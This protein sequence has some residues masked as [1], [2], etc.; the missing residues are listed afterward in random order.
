MT[1][2]DSDPGRRVAKDL[3]IPFRK[4]A[5]GAA[6]FAATYSVGNGILRVHVAHAAD[7]RV[8][9]PAMVHV[10]VEPIEAV[11]QM[12][13]EPAMIPAGEQ[14]IYLYMIRD[15]AIPSV[16]CTVKVDE[17]TIDRRTLQ[18]R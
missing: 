4:V 18:L 17:V 12:D 13:A 14:A 3:V 16:K 11:S 1:R 15:R 10:L 8:T 9:A 7:D 2:V 5:P 6:E